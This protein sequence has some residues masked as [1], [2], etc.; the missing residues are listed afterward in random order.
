MW[1]G[2]SSHCRRVLLAAVG[3]MLLAGV[4]R[5]A[6]A[7]PAPSIDSILQRAW[8]AA[9]MEPAPPCADEVFLRRAT[10]DLLG[11]IPTLEERREFLASPD[12]QRLIE[13]LLGSEEFISFWAELW[14]TQ[15]YGYDLEDTSGARLMLVDWLAAQLHS[16]RPYDEMVQELV[17]ATGESA[18]SAP[19]NFLLRYPEE[20]IVKVSRAFLGIRL[21]CARCHDH[22]FDRWTQQ[23]FA[24]MRR[25]FDT[26]EREEVSP[27]NVR[28]VDVVRNVEAEER[29]RFLSGAVPRTSQ[30]RSE[31]ALFVTRSRPFARNFANQLWYHF[32]G[33]G[34]V[35]PVDD[36]SRDNPPVVPELLEYLTDEARH[37]GFDL[38]HMIRLICNSRAYQLDS[39][40]EA[41]DS[42]RRALFAVRPIKPLLPEQLYASACTASG[43]APNAEERRNFVRAYYGDALEGDFASTWEYRETLQGLMSRLVAN[44]RP[45]SR[46][47]E[48]LFIR[49]LGRQPTAVEL[50]TCAGCSAGEV[51][52]LLVHS[53]EFA[54]NH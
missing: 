42:R 12:R 26:I 33:R 38:R 20:P 18:F 15:L 48:E 51:A 28:V 31:F 53:S 29:P 3:G 30:W 4:L 11:R 5:S 22:P 10:L 13:R 6:A 19:V 39:R 46:N 43:A 36:F 1:S 21:D 35:H 17:S 52:Y 45:A 47:V 50:E 32:L 24:G 16:R 2:K 44:T 34:I 8:S 14:T 49:Y 40:A 23:D 37:S 9:G 54:F 7:E 25:F 27:G 41:G